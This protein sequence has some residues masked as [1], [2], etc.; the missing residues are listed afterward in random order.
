MT[1]CMSNNYMRILLSL[2]ALFEFI[3]L[4]VLIS[5]AS[6]AYL[7]GTVCLCIIIMIICKKFRNPKDSIICAKSVLGITLTILMAIDFYD[8]WLPSGMV[9]RIANALHV[10]PSILLGVSGLILSVGG[11]FALCMILNT[12]LRLFSAWINKTKSSQLVMDFLLVLLIS[13]LEYISFEYSSIASFSLVFQKNILVCVFNIGILFAANTVLLL[14]FQRIKIALTI[15]SVIVFSWSVANYYTIQFHG[16]PLFFSEFINLR[17]ALTVA[18]DYNYKITLVVICEILLI[19]AEI[20]CIITYKKTGRITPFV[21][22]IRNRCISLLVC[23]AIVVVSY[24]T[25]ANTYRTWITWE[26]AI[27][28][29]G[30][31]S[32]SIRDL[33]NAMNPY[34]MPEGYTHYTFEETNNNEKCAYDDLP[35]IIVILNETFCDFDYYT[36]VSPD[37]DYLL[38]Y[39]SIPNAIY[40]NAIVPKIGGGTN[41]SEFE[42]LTSKS[43]YLLRVGAPFTYLSEEIEGRSVVNYLKEYGYTTIGMHC[44][45]ENNY[46]RNHAYPALGFDK[47]VLGNT[48]F[49]YF[50]CNGNRKW[51][52]SDNYK[53]LINQY[54]AMD[55]TS[56]K[57]IYLLTFQN[58]GGYEQNDS[59]L[60]TVHTQ[61]DFGDF[62]D[63]INEYLS[64]VRLSGEA[65]CKLTQHF[66]E[67]DRRVIICMVGDHAP[68]FINNIEIK[69]SSGIQDN[70]INMRTVPYIIWTNY[71]V[72]TSIYTEYASMVDLMPMVLKLSG[73]PLSHF[74]NTILDLHEELPIRTSDGKYVDRNYSVGMYEENDKYYDCLNEYYYMEYNS[75][76]KGK[77]YKESLFS[78]LSR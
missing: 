48:A 16:S 40:G 77:E 55:D 58:H 38:P 45:N 9:S 18:G 73:I 52:D 32:C 25:V 41:D 37:S 17:T 67:K 62:T 26:E 12:V 34:I 74:Y 51:L 72:E 50:G 69:E 7:L 2:V 75:L 43:T 22:I 29:C 11:F 57:L 10:S 56:P 3:A 36:D 53:D 1:K 35:D 44:E 31:I 27:K 76:L 54:E 68:S 33:E 66:Q 20:H 46:N 47:C 23:T 24:R 64:S 39:Y 6:Y 14:I 19:A 49:S 60:D 70:S 13:T 4:G 63:D 61:K 65:F 8:R 28:K 78:T 30:F 15:S 42:L 5:P 21:R 71:D 59:S